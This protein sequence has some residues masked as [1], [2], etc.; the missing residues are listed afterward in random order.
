M[1]EK[2]V[3]CL[4]YYANVHGE[5]IV[6]GEY[7]L[8]LITGFMEYVDGLKEQADGV[9]RAILTV[10]SLNKPITVKSLMTVSNYMEADGKEE[11]A[12][13]VRRAILTSIVGLDNARFKEYKQLHG[14]STAPKPI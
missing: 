14:L 13:G 2:L 3:G 5:E 6:I 8:I 4:Q 9:R 7:R 1:D 11:Q 10:N 12:L